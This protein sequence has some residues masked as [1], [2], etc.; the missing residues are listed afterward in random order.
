MTKEERAALVAECRASGLTAKEWCRQ[1]GIKYSQYCSWA[2]RV[3][4][5]TKQGETP[6]WVNVTLVKDDNWNN[7]IKITCGKFNILVGPDFNPTLLGEVLK[8]VQALC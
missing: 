1:N 6:Q 4:Q 8:V 3:N 2:T 7:E 5:E